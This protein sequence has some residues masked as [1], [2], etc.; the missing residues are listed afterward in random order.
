MSLVRLIAALAIVLAASVALAEPI[1]VWFDVDTANGVVKQRPRDVDDGLALI[2]AFHSPELKIRGV[3]VV[4]G[5]AD[6]VDAAPVAREIV[7][8]FGPKDLEVQTG[9]ASAN[10]LGDETAASKALIG[11]LERRPLTIL[12]LGPVTN[13]A[14]VLKNRPDLAPKINQ[15]IV[16]AARRPGFGFY[17]PGNPSVV[18]PDANFEKDAAGMQILLDSGVQIVFAGYEVSCDTWISRHDLSAIATTSDAGKWISET[19]QAWLERWE[20]SRGPKGFNPFDTLCVA[21]LTHPGMIETMP[22]T[23]HITTGPDDRAGTGVPA[24]RPTKPYLIAEPPVEKSAR[25]HIYCTAAKVEFHDV[26]IQRL[27]EAASN[28]EEKKMR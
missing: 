7:N 5:N 14:T 9:A 12:A 4:F 11:E 28:L 16:C 13:V 15:I 18:F 2:F 10:E 1:D 17:L 25:P 27:A 23:A 21:Y 3:S 22:A 26:L 19:S 6:L 20:K 8:R 24:T